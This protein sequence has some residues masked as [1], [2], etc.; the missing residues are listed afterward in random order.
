[1]IQRI[2]TVYLFLCFLLIGSLFLSPVA[3]YLAHDGQVYEQTALSISSYSDSGDALSVNPFPVGVLAGVIALIFLTSIFMF[4]NRR[5]QMRLVIFNMVL[6]VALLG[7]IYLY[8]ALIKSEI[9]ATVTFG[10]INISPI[11][12]LVLAFISF[13]RIRLDEALVKSYDRIR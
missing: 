10:S 13:H 11:V 4:K 8:S 2:Q 7:L 1:M 5:L 9:G 3:Q 6:I 12:A